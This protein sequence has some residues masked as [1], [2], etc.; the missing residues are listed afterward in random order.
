MIPYLVST[1]FIF[2]Y[3]LPDYRNPLH[4]NPPS[5]LPLST[6]KF[7]SKSLLRVVLR[8]FFLRPDLPKPTVDPGLLLPNM[9]YPLPLA[10][11]GHL[12]LIHILMR[13]H[14]ESNGRQLVILVAHEVVVE[15]PQNVSQPAG[16]I[17]QA[18][19][20]KLHIK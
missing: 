5:Y 11:L 7:M 20:Q 1:Y 14:L 2:F 12:L 16:V 4:S 15:W 18:L 6:I 17:S 8:L 9:K 3:I 13:H 10:I 19:P